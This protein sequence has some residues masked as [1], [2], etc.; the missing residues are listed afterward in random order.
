MSNGAPPAQT[1]RRRGTL[2]SRGP[3]GRLLVGDHVGQAAAQAAQAVR[4]A[5]L[6]PGLDR[7]FGCDAEEVGRV[8][9]QDPAAGSELA[10]NGMVTLYVAAPG[11]TPTHE[12]TAPEADSQRTPAPPVA[13]PGW[14]ATDTPPPDPGARRARKPRPAAD[15]RSHAQHPAA[16]VRAREEPA[17][18]PTV[19]Q[20]SMTRARET[21]AEPPEGETCQDAAYAVEE[22]PTQPHEPLTEHLEDPF[23]GHA[24]EVPGWRRVYPRRP[25]AGTLRRAL[26]WFGSHR[27]LALAACSLLTLWAGEA[28]TRAPAGQHARAPVASGHSTP[29]PETPSPS[30]PADRPQPQRT[31]LARTG[32][33]N[34]PIHKWQ[35][36]PS[37][38]QRARA[39]GTHHESAP[40]NAGTRPPPAPVGGAPEPA[41]PPAQQSPGGPFSP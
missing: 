16:P 39:G 8:V 1:Q 38:P 31:H 17:D 29:N 22:R 37:R 19:G 34:T 32:A 41:P 36:N 7:S 26:R 33:H 25:F 40:V 20:M 24:G 14:P 35:G 2:S 3:A 10:R 28:V 5:G 27:L 9:A 30:D 18:G 21:D 6:R 23:S 12:T 11:P 13:S 4:R 15:A